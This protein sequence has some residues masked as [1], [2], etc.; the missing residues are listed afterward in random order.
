MSVAQSE[1]KRA[2]ELKSGFYVP[3]L[4]P[5]MDPL[6][7]KTRKLYI[8]QF[9]QLKIGHKT[10]GTLFNKIGVVNATECWSCKNVEQF[11]MHLYTNYRK[12]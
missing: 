12:W 9:Y 4:K 3:S 8:A 1:N 5:E 11:I 10:I 7:V 6:L 2:R